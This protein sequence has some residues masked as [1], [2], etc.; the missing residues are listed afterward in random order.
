M[1]MMY[2]YPLIMSLVL[3][4]SQ[5]LLVSLLVMLSSPSRYSQNSVASQFL[6]C[7]ENEYLEKIH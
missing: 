7:P 3:A 1:M 6:S 4:R 5:A 2:P